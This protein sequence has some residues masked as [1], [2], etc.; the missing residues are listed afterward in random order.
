MKRMFRTWPVL[1]MTVLVPVSLLALPVVAFAQHSGGGSGTSSSGG[2][3]Q[4]SSGGGGQASSGGHAA[5]P[6]GG[7]QAASSGARSGGGSSGASARSAGGVGPHGTA[8]WRVGA[9]GSSSAAQARAVSSPGA[10]ANVAQGAAPGAMRASG[11]ARAVQT[12]PPFSRPGNLIGGAVPRSSVPAAS[13]GGGLTYYGYG[14]GPY[15]GN[16]Y[17]SYYGYGGL[18]SMGLFD[19]FGGLGGYGFGGFGGFSGF[20]GLDSFD[21]G[22]SGL[23]SYSSSSYGRPYG[24]YDPYARSSSTGSGS[25]SISESDGPFIADAHDESGALRLK[26]KPDTGS[27]YLDGELVGLV[28]K[29]DGLF[30]KLHLDGGN[31]R[32]EI[33]APGYKTLTFNVRIESGHTETYRGELEKYKN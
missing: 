19:Y 5:A 32:V 21:S 22:Y 13:G 6:S 25:S 7:G 30:Q 8:A 24:S 20:G 26:V 18:A 10:A 12:V 14:Y 11:V 17:G 3:G 29:Y 9:T 2:G 15:Y 23:S 1:T 31:H 16:G 27:V 4:A 28:N 33:R